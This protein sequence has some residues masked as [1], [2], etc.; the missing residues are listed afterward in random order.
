MKYKI[1]PKLAFRKIS[2][3]FFIVD[4]ESSYLHRLNEVGSL[5]WECL[6]CGMEEKKIIDKIVEEFEVDYNTAK[7]DFESFIEE[8]KEKKL[9]E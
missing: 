5:I 9:V 1:N 6:V 4:T 3:E 7:R 2:N 8:L